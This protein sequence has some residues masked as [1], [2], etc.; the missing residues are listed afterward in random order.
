MPHVKHEHMFN[1]EHTSKGP[2]GKKPNKQ[3]KLLPRVMFD[4]A[5]VGVPDIVVCD[6]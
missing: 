2:G 6:C 4:L 3:I 1:S 5:E